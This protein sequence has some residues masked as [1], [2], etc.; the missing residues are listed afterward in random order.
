MPKH[1]SS[2]AIIPARGGSK[3]IPRKNIK[4]FAGQPIIAY[5]I[6]AALASGL[7]SEVMV[8]TDDEEIA[9]VAQEYG[10]EVPFMRSAKN[11]NDFATTASVLLEVLQQYKHQGKVFDNVCCLYPTAPL[12]TAERLTETFEV[13][14]NQDLDSVFPVLA[15]SHPIQRALVMQGQRVEMREPENKSVRSQDLETTYHDSGQFYWLNVERFIMT[16]EIYMKNSGAIVLSEMEAQDIDN[17]ED[18]KLA[19]LKFKMRSKVQMFNS[20]KVQ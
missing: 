14:N 17:D 18:W 3:R 15:Y 19:E 8:S 6:K 5:S 9:A 16:Q 10:A 7:F 4:T 12:I 20:S 2:I 13:L 11:A 1:S